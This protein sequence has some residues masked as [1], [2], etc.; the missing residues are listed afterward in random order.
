MEVKE[1]QHQQRGSRLTWPADYPRECQLAE[2]DVSWRRASGVVMTCVG[3]F[4]W[5]DYSSAEDKLGMGLGST[6]SA[7][8]WTEKD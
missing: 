1:H 4:Y 2:Q 5:N 3:R 7:E 8:S 6:S